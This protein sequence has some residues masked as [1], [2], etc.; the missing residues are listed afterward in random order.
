MALG[1]NDMQVLRDL[2]PKGTA[3]KIQNKLLKRGVTFSVNYI[4]QVLDPE[5][6]KSNQKIIDC[7]FEIATA[8]KE[9]SI[10]DKQRLDFLAG[11]D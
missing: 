2:L 6:K 3:S 4:N 7:A 5:D 10:V 9:Q 11:K 1:K 8:I